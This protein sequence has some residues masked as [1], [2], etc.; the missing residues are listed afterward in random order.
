MCDRRDAL[1]LLN[2]NAQR[3]T[4]HSRRNL[5]RLPEGEHAR[6]LG[7]DTDASGFGRLKPTA[8]S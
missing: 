8:G 3:L 6:T 7:P 5:A 2:G 4:L 1:L